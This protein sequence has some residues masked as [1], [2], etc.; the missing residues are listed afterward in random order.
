MLKCYANMTSRIPTLL[1]ASI[2]IGCNSSHENSNK[3]IHQDKIIHTKKSDT[4]VID[5]PDTNIFHQ[6][7][8]TTTELILPKIVRPEAIGYWMIPTEDSGLEH[9]T[10]KGISLLCITWPGAF[11]YDGRYLTISMPII[12]NAT[13]A[14]PLKWISKDEHYKFKTSWKGD[15]LFYTSP[16]HREEFMACFKD[17]LFVRTEPC[18]TLNHDWKFYKVGPEELTDSWKPLIRQRAVFNYELS[19]PR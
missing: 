11:R 19:E 8:T 17:S 5:E 18:D 4:Q 2:L 6:V 9:T 14:T 15:S 13:L 7:D 1:L 3:D 10:S 12:D 16:W